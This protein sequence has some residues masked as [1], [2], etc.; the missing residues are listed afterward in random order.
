[1]LGLL[2]LIRTGERDVQ[3]LALGTDL[4]AVGLNLNATEPLHPAFGT[5]WAR[6]PIAVEP[7]FSLPAC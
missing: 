1:M 5:P 7:T 3:S 4:M 2:S 6:E